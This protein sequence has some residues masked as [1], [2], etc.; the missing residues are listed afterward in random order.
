M[1]EHAADKNAADE[2]KLVV[3]QIIPTAG[4]WLAVFD[5]GNGGSV[6]PVACWALIQC[7]T[8]GNSYIAPMVPHD[9]EITDATQIEGFRDSLPEMD[10]EELS[11]YLTGEGDEED[12][13]TSH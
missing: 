7:V 4:P 1:S 2:H 13:E 5:D 10:D 3:Q 9:G 8:H 12:D 11:D 6:R